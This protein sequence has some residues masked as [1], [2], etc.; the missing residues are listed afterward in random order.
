VDNTYKQ[1]LASRKAREVAE[2]NLEAEL[3]RLDVGLSN[4]FTVATVQERLTAQRL[5]EINAIIRYINAVADFERAQK[6]PG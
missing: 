3:T 4:N 2:K 5:A 6:F 1:F